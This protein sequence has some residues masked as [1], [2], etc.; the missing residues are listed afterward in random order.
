MKC[1]LR[2]IGF[3]GD[4][5]LAEF[6]QVDCLGEECAWWDA[7]SNGCS[8]YLISRSLMGIFDIGVDIKEKMPHT[9]QFRK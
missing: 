2:L 3:E 6:P 9:G 1:P 4:L 7:Q 5:G 8:V